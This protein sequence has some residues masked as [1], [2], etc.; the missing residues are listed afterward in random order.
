MKRQATSHVR[1]RE[2]CLAFALAFLA[3]V[4]AAQP[5]EFNVATYIS[6]PRKTDRTR[7]RSGATW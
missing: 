3:Q 5:L 6:T 2:R 7:G 1:L 4:A